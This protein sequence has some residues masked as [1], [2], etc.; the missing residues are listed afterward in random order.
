MSD[1]DV[2][3][4][5]IIAHIWLASWSASTNPGGRIRGLIG[6]FLFLSTSAFFMWA[7]E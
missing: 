3:G 1:F 4:F 5:I 7:R 6:S 2:W